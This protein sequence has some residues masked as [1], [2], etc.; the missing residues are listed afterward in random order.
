MTIAVTQ[1]PSRQASPQRSAAVAP[2]PVQASRAAGTSPAVPRAAT[3]ARQAAQSPATP[4]AAPFKPKWT[5]APNPAAVTFETSGDLLMERTT[6]LIV[7]AG[8]DGVGKTSGLMSIADWVSKNSPE[9]QIYVLDA[10]K[11]GGFAKVLK[12][13]GNQ[14]PGNIMYV[15]C[16]GPERFMAAW[17]EIK[18]RAKPATETFA[19]DWIFIETAGSVWTMAQDF[20]HLIVEGVTKSEFL[21]RKR[22]VGGGRLSG[23]PNP[24]NPDRYW[25]YVY[26]F[27]REGFMRQVLNMKVNIV[28][29]A[30]MKKMEGRP[31]QAPNPKRVDFSDEHGIDLGVEGQPD[32]TGDMDTTIMLQKRRG[33]VHAVVLKDRVMVMGAQRPDMVLR[34]PLDFFWELT[35]Y[36]AK[37]PGL[38]VVE[39]GAGEPEAGEVDTAT[40]DTAT[41]E[42]E[43]GPGAAEAS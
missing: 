17:E 18:R 23:S 15:H 22:E 7:L 13:F 5:P 41:G 43:A 42:P 9:A 28:L 10:E 26:E 30:R 36:R 34:T 1:A 37:S 35:D 11:L 25:N 33:I 29:T 8:K 19:G 31:G 24:R 32:L 16:E 2:A 4:T 20:G 3:T 21:A 40:G 14:A 39:E 38:L 27:Y 6:E 12:A